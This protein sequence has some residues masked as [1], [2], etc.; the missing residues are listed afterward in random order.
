[1]GTLRLLSWSAGQ[2]RYVLAGAADAHG[3]MRAAD[4]MTMR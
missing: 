1:V 2:L 4:L 3:L